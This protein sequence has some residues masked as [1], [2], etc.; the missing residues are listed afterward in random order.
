MKSKEEIFKEII[1][2]FNGNEF[3][4]NKI[5][6][7][8]SK[9]YMYYRCNK[10]LREFLKEKIIEK[11]KNGE[12]IVKDDI[13]KWAIEFLEKNV[14]TLANMIKEKD[15][16]EKIKKEREIESSLKSY[17]KYYQTLSYVFPKEIALLF[18]KYVESNQNNIRNKGSLLKYIRNCIARII[19]ES[20]MSIEEIEKIFKEEAEKFEGIRTV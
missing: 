8:A 17:R 10:E 13:A 15:K 20:K 4:L 16:I 3:L 14:K 6:I 1:E 11:A 19:K 5:D 2:D 7:S 9:E 12:R 18:I